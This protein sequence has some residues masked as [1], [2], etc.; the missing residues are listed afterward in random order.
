MT[1]FKIKA[2]KRDRSA[3]ETRKNGMVP[4][5][6]YGKKFD[7]QSLELEAT[8]FIRLYKEAGS[9]NLV[10]LEI[11]G[12]NIKTLIHDIQRDPLKNAITHAD[13]LKIDMKEKIRTGIPLEFVGETDLVIQQEGSLLTNKDSVEVECLP[14]DLVDHINVDISLL[15]EF[16]MNIKVSDLRVPSGIEVLDDP[17][18]VIALVQPPRSEEELEA[19]NEEVVEDVEAV[20]VENAG[21]APAEGEEAEVENKP[22]EKKKE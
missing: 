21:E 9:S 18:E 15:T 6:I 16:D 14:A 2:I 22:E 1:D 5:V 19:L 7:N 12:N 20:E 17:E 13:F 4:A 3:K 10:D 11:D 8:E